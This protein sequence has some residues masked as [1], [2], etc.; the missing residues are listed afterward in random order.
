MRI[1]RLK[2]GFEVQDGDKLYS[3]SITPPALNFICHISPAYRM[4]GKLISRP[5]KPILFTAINLLKKKHESINS[6]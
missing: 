6:L 5:A 3:M 4:A 1:Y 2:T